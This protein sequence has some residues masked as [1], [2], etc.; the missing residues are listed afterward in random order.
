MLA[1]AILDWRARYLQS[2]LGAH[3]PRTGSAFLA[4]YIGTIVGYQFTAPHSG[5]QVLVGWL[6][7]L[8]ALARS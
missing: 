5:V 4:V 6:I 1:A 7:G 3:S 2:K 8:S